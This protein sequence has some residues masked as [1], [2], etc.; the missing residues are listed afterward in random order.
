MRDIQAE[1]VDH[2]KKNGF[3]DD[4]KSDTSINL[5]KGD[6]AV[7]VGEEGWTLVDPAGEWHYGH[8]NN[9]SQFFS[10]YSKVAK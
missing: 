3:S 10:V 5:K 1:F 7:W 4:G 9:R 2:L 6:I 8:N